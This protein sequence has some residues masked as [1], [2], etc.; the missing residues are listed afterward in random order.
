MRKYYLFSLKSTPRIKGIVWMYFNPI[1]L[2]YEPRSFTLWFYVVYYTHASVVVFIIDYI[3]KS[4]LT[5]YIVT[6]KNWTISPISFFCTNVE[7]SILLINF[8]GSIDRRKKRLVIIV[9]L[10]LFS[11][12]LAIHC[13][14]SVSS[15]ILIYYNKLIRLI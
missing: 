10:R 11:G 4:H 7:I 6:Y 5:N 12:L 1:R 15:G 13:F 8:Q 2:L 9:A 14:L 3:A